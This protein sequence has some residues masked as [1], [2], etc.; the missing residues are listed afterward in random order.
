MPDRHHIKPLCFGGREG[1]HV[2]L[3]LKPPST[4]FRK[5]AGSILHALLHGGDQTGWPCGCGEAVPERRSCR[6]DG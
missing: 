1:M 4:I 2:E 3:R 5:K 6:F